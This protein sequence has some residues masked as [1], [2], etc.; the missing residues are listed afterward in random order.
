LCGYV[1]PF[2]IA[3]GT[4]PIP[5]RKNEYVNLNDCFGWSNTYSNSSVFEIPCDWD[6]QFNAFTSCTIDFSENYFWCTSN[7]QMTIYLTQK[8]MQ[9]NGFVSGTKNLNGYARIFLGASFH[10][11]YFGAYTQDEYVASLK[12]YR[13]CGKSFNAID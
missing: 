5:I 8:L 11:T 6:Y 12:M 1:W 10:S 3:R 13:R 4:W 2:P 9:Y 7:P